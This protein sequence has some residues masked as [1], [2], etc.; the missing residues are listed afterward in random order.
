MNELP[1]DVT[2]AINE[3]DRQTIASTSFYG[4]DATPSRAREALEKVIMAYVLKLDDTE[5]ARDALHA[6]LRALA[7]EVEARKQL[8]AKMEATE[9]ELRSRQ[10][11]A[12]M[13][14]DLRE[15]ADFL[16]RQGYDAWRSTLLNIEQSITAP[17]TYRRLP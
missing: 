6:G 16:G 4:R 7:K 15:C 5:L 11:T 3:F 14:A 8:T 12:E 2:K 10:G 1:E 13:M 17:E 9:I